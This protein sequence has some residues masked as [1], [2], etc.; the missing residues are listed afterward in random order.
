MSMI[1]HHHFTKEFRRGFR[2]GFGAPVM[3]FLP[4]NYNRVLHINPGVE[5]AWKKVA[6]SLNSATAI[7]GREIGGRK[8]GGG[9]I[10]QGSR[11]N[12][13]T[14]GRAHI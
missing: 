2:E 13:T 9:I 1:R 6:D 4:I 5:G 11:E 14:R 3:L 12:S 10:G 7:V 8:T